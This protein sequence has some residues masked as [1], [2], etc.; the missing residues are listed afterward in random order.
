[1]KVKP[2]LVASLIAIA[3]MIA[4]A[5]WAAGQLP[6]GAELPTHW[7]TAGKA[8]DWMPAL[9]A[10]LIAPVLLLFVS[11]LFAFIPRLEPLQDR[12]EAS[13][14]LLRTVWIAMI[15]LT[16][17]LQG[18]ISAPVFGVEPRSELVLFAVGLL[19]VV[20]G[21]VLPKSRPGFFVGI[22][23]PWT[24]VSTDNWI[25]THR[26]GGKCF[27][28]GGAL[29]MLAGLGDW[30]EGTRIAL[31]FGAIAIA[32]LIPL[33]YSWWLWHTGRATA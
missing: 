6:A 28:A 21:N 24:I 16:L 2:L 11:I 13:A 25:A 14:P 19:F 27:M 23:T 29:M 17:F 32:A 8:D 22:R 10:L 3:A 31:V 26:L 18:F 1:M 9:Q 20:L 12:L 33:G 30:G 4:Y 15:A 5:F 7:N